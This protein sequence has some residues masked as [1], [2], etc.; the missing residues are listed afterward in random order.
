MW[1]G[2]KK[3]DLLFFTRK[4]LISP[5]HTHAQ[6]HVAIF[7]QSVLSGRQESEKKR[8]QSLFSGWKL[9]KGGKGVR[10]CV[11]L[12]KKGWVVVQ[13]REEEKT[14]MTENDVIPLSLSLSLPCA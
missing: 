10:A 2:L 5:T 8:A 9:T 13:K 4:S 7:L 1:V 3:A 14:K 12:R 6:V 11:G